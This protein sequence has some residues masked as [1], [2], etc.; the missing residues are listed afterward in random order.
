MR[1]WCVCARMRAPPLVCEVGEGG[2]ELN[3][4][5]GVGEQTLEVR[6]VCEGEMFVCVCGGVHVGAGGGGGGAVLSVTTSLT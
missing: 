3:R 2:E 4:E 6:K 5:R 1:V